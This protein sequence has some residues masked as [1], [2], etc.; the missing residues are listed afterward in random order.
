MSTKSIAKTKTVVLV[1]ALIRMNAGKKQLST[2]IQGQ[3]FLDSGHL[4]VG[5]LTCMFGDD[6]FFPVFGKNADAT[7]RSGFGSADVK[8]TRQ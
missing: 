6:P 7:E 1:F 8:C 4:I 3:I 5:T 2:K